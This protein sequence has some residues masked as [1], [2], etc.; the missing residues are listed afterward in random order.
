MSL[1]PAS[2]RATAGEKE[3]VS[4]HIA[5]YLPLALP[6]LAAVCARW[7]GARLEPRT[8]TWLLTAAALLLAAVS[9]AAV[10][11]LAATFL[12]QIPLLAVRQPQRTRQKLLHRSRRPGADPVRL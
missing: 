10:A 6:M 3:P 4:V 7:L 11:I 5:V 12:G 9:G 2:G 8:A 1:L